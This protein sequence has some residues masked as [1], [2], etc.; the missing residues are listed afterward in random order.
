MYAK[1]NKQNDTPRQQNFLLF[2]ITIFKFTADSPQ[3]FSFF[4]TVNLTVKFT[5]EN[6]FH[7]E[8]VM[9]DLNWKFSYVKT[10]A[11]LII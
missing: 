1:P 8:A 7:F 9:F 6:I 3:F 2:L 4:L 11:F 5:A 10:L